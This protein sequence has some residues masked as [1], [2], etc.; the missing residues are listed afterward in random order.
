VSLSPTSSRGS[1]GGA[2]SVTL[3]STTTLAVDGVFDVASISQAYNDLVLVMNVRATRVASLFDTMQMRFN[4]DSGA[5][6]LWQRLGVNGATVTGAGGG[7]ATSFNTVDVPAATATAGQFA[8]V[9]LTIAGYTSATWQKTFVGAAFGQNGTAQSIQQ[10]S[11]VWASTAA[12]N[13]VGFFGVI[14][15]NLLT[16]SVLRIYGRL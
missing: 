3:L 5:N 9:E 11:G 10:I 7:G 8:Q 6:Y 16:G 14:T 15:A 2:G 13:R 12:V 4:N 1:S